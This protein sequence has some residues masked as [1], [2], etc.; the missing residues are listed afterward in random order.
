MATLLNQ[1]ANAI[2]P[3]T[4]DDFKSMIG[5]HQGMARSNRF[6]V[7]MSPPQQSLLNLDLQGTITSALSGTF[8]IGSLI[9]DPRDISMLCESCSF[10]SR[11]ISTLDY[12]SVRQNIKIPNGYVNED[13]TMDFH[14][15][16]DY[17]M[18]KIFD[19]WLGL[20]LDIPKYRARYDNEYTS[21]VVIQQL[22]MQNLPIYGV[23]LKR[24]WPVTVTNVPLNNNETDG[25]MKLT[26]TFTFEDWEPEGSIKTIAS[27]VS[28]MLGGI[29]K[30]L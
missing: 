14:L 7:M 26:V 20:V 6:A 16:N 21:D 10:P 1:V 9:N 4:I 24:A 25:V 23:R 15:T 28:N 5:K 30:L 29:T 12:Q 19:R 11:S 13:V 2:T 8:S 27:G 22:N 3:N 17:Y 18:K